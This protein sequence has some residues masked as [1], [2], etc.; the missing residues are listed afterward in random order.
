MPN[1]EAGTS[2]FGVRDPEHAETDLDRFSDAGLDA[3]LHTFSERD[4]E[5]Y[6]ETMADIVAASHDRSLSVYVNPWGVGGVFGGEAFSRFVARNPDSRQVLNTGERV[7]AACFNDPA[8]REFVREW[9]HDAAG[10]GADVLFWDEPHWHNVHWYG[11]DHPNDVWCCRCEHCRGL[12]RERYD[13]SM[14][15]T[16]TERVSTFRE[17]SMLDFL[18]EMM[19]LTRDEG[20]ENAVCLMPTQS[21][22]HGPRDW[23]QLAKNDHIDVLATDPYWAAFTEDAEP[24]EYVARFGKE[25]VE[26]T[27]DHDLRSQ[28]WIQGFGLRGDSAPD[29]VRTAT[30]TALDLADSVFMWGYDGCRAISKI[31]CAEPMAVWEAYLDELP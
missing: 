6:R 4:R 30:R 8:F 29:D 1:I 12:Y 18:D 19:A 5:F 25:L 28:L 9:T 15:A 22:D 3:V 7:S 11:D 17:E 27:D 10:L 16:E 2:Y 13:E 21:A 26:I 14:P 20:A 24:G 23:A 31:A